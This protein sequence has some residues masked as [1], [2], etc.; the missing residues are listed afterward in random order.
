MKFSGYSKLDNGNH[1]ME[2]LELKNH[3]F[4]IGCQYH[5]EF[6]TQYNLPHPLFVGL[7][8]AMIKKRI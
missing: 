6:K 4:Y 5:P 8:K 7:I 2:L 1:L 3:I